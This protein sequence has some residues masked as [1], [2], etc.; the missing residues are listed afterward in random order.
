MKHYLGLSWRN[1]PVPEKRRSGE[2]IF[3]E[4]LLVLG[5][6]LCKAD[7]LVSPEEIVVFKQYFGIDDNTYPGASKIFMEAAKTSED[8]KETAGRIFKLL[9]AKTE[10]LEYILIGL[11]QVA[12]A[13]GRIHKTEGDFIRIVA[14]EFHFSGAAI[15]RL[16]LI[17][18]QAQERAHR[19]QDATTRTRPANLRSRHLEILGLDDN[20]VFDEIKV[21]YRD[22]ARKHH[23]DLLRAQGV[24]IDDIKNAEEILKVINSAYEWLARHHRNDAKATA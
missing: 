6:K 11:M 20:A 22:L 23:P 3:N 5:A 18:E 21:A 9:G 16:F 12:A 7:G 4:A 19:D 14:E 10:P 24:P 15:H 2:E 17:F 13:D 8:I 1:Q